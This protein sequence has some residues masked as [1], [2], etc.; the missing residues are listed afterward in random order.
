M[1]ARQIIELGQKDSLKPT[2]AYVRTYSAEFDASA[3]VGWLDPNNLSH[4]VPN[5]PV[6]PPYESP[7]RTE[8]A[9]PHRGEAPVD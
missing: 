7:F 4:N 2:N 3:V 1:L 8:T 6:V 5:G 9:S